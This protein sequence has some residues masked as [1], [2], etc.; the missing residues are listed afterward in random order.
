[1]WSP[2]VRRHRRTA[3]SLGVT[4]H[5]QRGHSRDQARSHLDSCSLAAPQ[6]ASAAPP[7]FAETLTF[8]AV[9]FSRQGKAS[10]RPEPS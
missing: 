3:N 9:E 7:T 8:E 2:R 10:S 1:M 5:S 4:R 6:L